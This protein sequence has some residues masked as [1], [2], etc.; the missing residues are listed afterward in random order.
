MVAVPHDLLHLVRAR[1][2]VVGVV[3]V[4]RVLQSELAL[5]LAFVAAQNSLKLFAENSICPK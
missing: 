4:G 2:F 5:L 3:K 1:H